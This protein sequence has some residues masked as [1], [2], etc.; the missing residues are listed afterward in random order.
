M[1]IGVADIRLVLHFIVVNIEDEPRQRIFG[2]IIPQLFFDMMDFAC[3]NPILR[4]RNN[5]VLH[6]K[7][8]PIT[9][10]WVKL[11]KNFIRYVLEI[12]F[13]SIFQQNQN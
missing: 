7:I 5:F 12:Y 4:G 11:H 2:D 8:I 10:I 3:I 1:K 6:P 13:P 9:S